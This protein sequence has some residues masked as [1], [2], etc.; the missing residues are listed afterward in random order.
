MAYRHIVDAHALVW[1]LVDSPKLG[2]N[3]RV[4]MTN[5]A[6]AL[7]LPIIALAEACWL[8]EKGKAPTIPSVAALLEAVDADQRV[9]IVPLDRAI[10]DLSHTLIAITEMHDRLIV[11]TTL[12]LAGSGEAVALLTC[13]GSITASGLV[14]TIW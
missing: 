14:P 4:V 13:D 10:L 5:P 1:S 11:A 2:A 9:I 6:S 8:V 12:W 3:A 7:F